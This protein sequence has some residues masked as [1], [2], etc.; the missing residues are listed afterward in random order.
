[1]PSAKRSTAGSSVTGELHRELA[2]ALSQAA[3]F[4]G[5][6]EHLAQ[7]NFRLNQADFATL[8]RAGNQT[9]LASQLAP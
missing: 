7:R 3:K 9:S 2:L 4:A 8:I 5:D 6:M 1:M